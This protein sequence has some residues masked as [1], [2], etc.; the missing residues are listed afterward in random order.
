MGAYRT[1]LFDLDGTL[2]DSKEGINKSFTHAF[3]KLGIIVKNPDEFEKYIGIDSLEKVFKKY[4]LT[5]TE[6]LFAISFFREYYERYG[7]YENSL[8]KGTDN[9]LNNL[10]IRGKKIALATSKPKPFAEKILKKNKIYEYFDVIEG[11][12]LENEKLTKSDIIKSTLNQLGDDCYKESV[13]VG[14]RFYDI[15]GARDNKI[16]CIAVEYG[17]NNGNE[18][19]NHKPDYKV[20]DIDELEKFLINK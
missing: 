5:K 13:M 1:V 8:Y 20:S 12:N 11:S 18:F 2:I 15:K 17:Y 7:I 10:K 19:I 3:K 16:D 6:R 9:L 4:D 14:D